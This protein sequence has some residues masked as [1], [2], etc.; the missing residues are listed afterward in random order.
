MRDN[1]KGVRFWETKSLEEMSVSEWESLCDGCGKCCAFKIRS[2]ETDEVFY[3]SY[4]CRLLDS[5]AARCTDYEHRA[6]HVPSCVT[7]S[8]QF[9]RECDWLPDT[10]AYTKLARGEPLEWWHPLVSGSADTVHSAG[11]SVRGKLSKGTKSP[12]AASPLPRY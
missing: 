7:L 1:R 10:C 2:P 8:P 4:A 12:S 5:E 3:T 6:E 11:I 9:V